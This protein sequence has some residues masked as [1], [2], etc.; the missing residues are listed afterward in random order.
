METLN[1]WMGSFPAEFLA[2]AVS[3]SFGMLIISFF[4]TVFR[5]VRGPSV[6]DRV[7]ALDF[8]FTLGVTFVVIFAIATDRFV[9]LDIAIALGL[10]GFLATVAYARFV[11]Q[12]WWTKEVGGND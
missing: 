5:L 1:Q 2:L 6:A 10:V 4:L 8:L 7:M 3:I 11:Y 9:Y 12:H